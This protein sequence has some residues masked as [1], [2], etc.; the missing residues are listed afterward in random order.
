MDVCTQPQPVSSHNSARYSFFLTGSILL[1][2]IR[3]VIRVFSQTVPLPCYLFLVELLIIMSSQTYHTKFE[4]NFLSCYAFTHL[5][6]SG[7]FYFVC[8]V[9]G[10]QCWIVLT[11]SVSDGLLGVF[12][13]CVGL[14][15][16]PFFLFEQQ[17][18]PRC[19]FSTI[20]W[21]NKYIQPHQIVNY[22]PFVL[23]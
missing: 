12:M 8:L 14:F 17:F 19:L 18:L 16:S 23:L 20:K 2:R 15:E 11:E 4:E 3:H 5:C 21:S 6:H 13:Q 7:S 9:T 22:H 10:R 1:L